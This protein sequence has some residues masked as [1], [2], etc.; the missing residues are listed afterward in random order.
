LSQV[1]NIEEMSLTVNRRASQLSS[2]LQFNTD[3]GVDIDAAA[4]AEVASNPAV[5]FIPGSPYPVVLTTL[6]IRTFLVWIS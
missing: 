6:H 5:T 4:A 1:T 2:R 3:D